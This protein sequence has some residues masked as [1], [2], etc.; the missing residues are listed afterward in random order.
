MD[1]ID[2]E[3]ILD[4]MSATGI[5]VMREDDHRILYFNKHVQEV[6]PGIQKGMICHEL[7]GS[8]CT[9]CPLRTIGDRPDSRSVIF[10]HPFGKIVDIVAT[11]VLWNDTVPAFVITVSPHMEAADFAYHSIFRINLTQDRYEVIKETSTTSD[12]KRKTGCFSFQMEQYVKRG[13]VHPDDVERF[14]PFS[15]PGYLVNALCSGLKTLTCAY[16][17]RTPSGFRW[18]RMEFVPDSEYTE[19]SRTVMLYSRDVHQIMQEVLDRE[20]LTARSQNVIRTLS[21]LNFDIYTIDLYIGTVAP[22]RIDGQM[23]NFLPSEVLPWNKLMRSHIKARLHKDYQEEFE[24]KFSL[25]S[26]RRAQRNGKSKIELL[27]QWQSDDGYRYICITAYFDSNSQ[28]E[29]YMVLALQDEDDHIRGELVRTQRDIQ[30]AAIIK[31]RYSLI[32]T[33]HPESGRCECISLEE[34][35]APKS[36]IGDY[37][38]YLQQMLSDSVNSKDADKVRQTLSLEHIREKAAKTADYSEEFCQYRLNTLPVQ[39]IEQHVIY[40]RQEKDILVNILER[41]ITNEKLEEEHRR[42]ATQEKVDL[43]QSL[44]S[45]FFATYY[46][47][48]ECDTFRSVTQLDE[49]GRLLGNEFNYTAGLRT[50]ANTYVHP[51]DRAEYLAVMDCTNLRQVLSAECPFV[52]IEYRKIPQ[53]AHTVPEKYDWVRATAVLA[54]TSDDGAPRTALYVTQDVTES[55]QKEAREQRALQDACNVADQASASKSEF[56][57][58]MSHDIRTPLNGIIGTAAIAASHVYDQE[59]MS[60]YLN[61]IMD[62]S[63]RLLSMVNEVLDMSQIDSGKVDLAENKFTLS[64][65]IHDLTTVIT[66]SVREKG[67]ELRVDSTHVSHESVVGDLKLL[68]RVFMNI[69]GNAVKYTPPS[70]LIEMSVTE[71]ESRECGYGHYDFTVK[72]NGIGMDQKFVRHIFDPFSR[73]EDSR[74]SKVQ[75]TGLGMTITQNI[76]RM[77]GGS[78]GIESTPDIGTTVTVSLLLRQQDREET[79]E[80]QAASPSEA[81][82]DSVSDV[83]FE[84]HRILLVDD[85][86]INREIAAEIVGSTGAEVETATNGRE[87]LELFQSKEIGYYSLII[88]DIQMPV[89]NGYEATREIRGLQRADASLIPII[90]MSAND[91]TEDRLASRQSGMNEHLTKPLDIERLMTCMNRWI[92]RKIQ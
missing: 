80:L 55:K 15:R 40:N 64:D 44:S 33:L 27:C 49:V 70:G 47:N 9:Y 17:R 32:N 85:I 51:D 37:A 91:S 83:S 75:G 5:Y 73:V 62:A 68:E 88:M 36:H 77:M 18:C 39:W 25:E 57:S 52:A 24:Q 46:I 4:S 81:S 63:Q 65:M 90:A 29:R 59:R 86:D 74:I 72:D 82:Q 19:S 8:S 23:Q 10:D 34:A 38:L 58:R 43:I 79:N 78:I 3:K 22:V 26:L 66:P 42:Q 48:L 13:N 7:W 6:T 35:G 30:M 20:E 69:L 2:Y 45:M 50:Y 71:Q 21:K 11:R 60:D 67:H 41:N 28:S 54:H 84:G 16:R 12:D 53:V 61:Q 31:S 87:A 1:I 92:S 76:V 56:L 14:L 89:M